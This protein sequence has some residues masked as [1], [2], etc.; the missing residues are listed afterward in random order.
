MAHCPPNQPCCSS[1]HPSVQLRREPPRSP[2]TFAIRRSVVIESDMLKNLN[3][4]RLNGEFCDIELKVQE[5]TFL[6]HRNVLAAS[7][8]YFRV[9]VGNNSFKERS[10]QT[11]ELLDV[12]AATFAKLLDFVYGGSLSVEDDL[13]DLLSAASYLQIQQAE[14]ILDSVIRNDTDV[15]DILKVMMWPGLKL[16]SALYRDMREIVCS[17]FERVARTATFLLLPFATLREILLSAD[18]LLTD[19]EHLVEGV[20]QWICHDVD[21]RFDDIVAAFQLVTSARVQPSAGFGDLLDGVR[22]SQ[23]QADCLR[24]VFKG[25]LAAATAKEATARRHDASPAGAAPPVPYAYVPTYLNTVD[26]EVSLLRIRSVKKLPVAMRS[27]DRVEAALL[28]EHVYLTLPLPFA[29]DERAALPAGGHSFYRCRID[30]YAWESLP[31]TRSLCNDLVAFNGTLYAYQQAVR[32]NLHQFYAYDCHLNRW[33]ALPACAVVRDHAGV[34]CD[35]RLLYVAGGRPVAGC[36]AP[37][38]FE[39][40]MYDGRC[41]SWANVVPANKSGVLAA[42]LFGA[43]LSKRVVYYEGCLY[44]LQENAFDVLEMRSRRWLSERSHEHRPQLNTYPG[45]PRFAFPG[46]SHLQLI[47]ASQKF[48]YYSAGNR[49]WRKRN[50]NNMLDDVTPIKPVFIPRF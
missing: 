39:I 15:E 43:N 3:Q 26:D 49:T 42:G 41:K 36:Y 19:A 48:Y 23:H 44:V 50:A 1:M 5:R 29:G 37:A 32:R 24:T 7:S 33:F 11:I 30:T 22:R 10:K 13:I 46:K 4:F 40:Q 20:I 21:G 34:T 9:L 27:F 18:L 17:H 35:A 16:K 8:N 45:K 14:E 25:A 31:A 47:D 2:R 38:E 6:C 12:K 28:N